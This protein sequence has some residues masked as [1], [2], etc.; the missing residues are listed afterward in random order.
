[1]HPVRARTTGTFAGAAAYQQLYDSVSTNPNGAREE[2]AL[3][4]GTAAAAFKGVD[5]V[6]GIELLNEP[7][8]GN[9]WKVCTAHAA[10]PPRNPDKS[11][12]SVQL[13][14][15]S[16][17]CRCLCVLKGGGYPGYAQNAL[18]WCVSIA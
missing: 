8:A 16:F 11:Q 15:Y 3:F 9:F 5:S 7:F 1:M 2:F 12:H 10:L 4:W 18:T 14:W 6:V 17:L 13:H